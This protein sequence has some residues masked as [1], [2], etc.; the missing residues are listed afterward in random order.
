MKGQEI[1]E[2][3]MRYNPSHQ[4]DMNFVNSKVWQAQRELQAEDIMIGLHKDD[5]R[6]IPSAI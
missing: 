2:N 3:G 5:N 6:N 1:V 4:I